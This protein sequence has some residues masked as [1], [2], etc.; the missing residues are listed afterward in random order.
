V[1]YDEWIASSVQQVQVIREVKK[2][3]E[4]LS[5]DRLLKEIEDEWTTLDLKIQHIKSTYEEEQ[6]TNLKLKVL[7]LVLDELTEF[8]YRRKELSLAKSKSPAIQASILT[9]QAS[10]RRLPNNRIK[11]SSGIGRARKIRAQ[12][13]NLLTF[14]KLILSQ[15]GFG[16]KHPSMLDDKQLSNAISTWSSLKKP[17]EVSEFCLK[18]S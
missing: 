8:N 6:K 1:E 13:Q 4:N 12:A 16:S 9:A 17:G 3:S 10:L 11:F 14:G 15:S 2:A 7:H 18:T 5:A